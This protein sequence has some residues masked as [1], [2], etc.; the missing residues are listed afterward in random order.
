MN[1][2]IRTTLDG[3]AG[4]RI[5]DWHPPD[6]ESRD[7]DVDDLARILH[8][9]VN[10][11][12]GVTFVAPY[13]MADARAFWTAEVLRGV[14][15]GSRRVLVARSGSQ[16]VG[17]VQILLAAPPNQRHRCEVVKLMVH[18]DARRRGIAR[19]LMI[20]LEEVARDEAR[21]LLT[22]DTWTGSAAEA[23]YRSLGYVTLGVI[24]RYAR[25]SLTPELLPVT[26]MYKELRGPSTP[27]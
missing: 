13:S 25:A 15:E 23:L 21:T 12:E 19:A 6:D 16:I 10:S 24:P 17:S 27:S 9:T 4:V 2:A 22:L 8:A 3:P 11:R 5:V 20:A 14:R 1:G 26:F 18:P 7:A